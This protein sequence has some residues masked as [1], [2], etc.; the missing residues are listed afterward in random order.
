MFSLRVFQLLCSFARGFAI[1]LRPMLDKFLLFVRLSR[2]AL[3]L[4]RPARV[5][6]LSG[7]ES[8]HCINSPLLGFQAS[9]GGDGAMAS[10]GDI[11][12][13]LE[14]DFDALRKLRDDDASGVL[15]VWSRQ[16]EIG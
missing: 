16:G 10:P 14:A 8:S 6:E 5:A 11:P 1:D 4:Q 12:P 2:G 13:S 15:K 7:C 9:G 3:R